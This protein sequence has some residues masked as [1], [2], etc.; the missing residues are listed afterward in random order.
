MKIGFGI[1]AAI[2]AL[3]L[4]TVTPPAQACNDRG[5]CA[6]APGNTRGAPSP[7]A[8]AGLPI[9]AIG[10]GVYWLIRRHRKQN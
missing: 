9:L 8:G 10:Y 7:I 6:N 2:L 1:T 3:A 5:N 4:T